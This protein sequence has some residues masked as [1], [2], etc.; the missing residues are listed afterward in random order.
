MVPDNMSFSSPLQCDEHHI[1]PPHMSTNK[2]VSTVN[3]PESRPSTCCCRDTYSALTTTSI[4]LP[5]VRTRECSQESSL[6]IVPDNMLL[7]RSY[8][9]PRERIVNDTLVQLNHFAVCVANEIRIASPI[10]I[11]RSIQRATRCFKAAWRANPPTNAT[12]QAQST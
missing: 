6:G 11:C 1:I 3:S 5:H 2:A 7:L 4:P 12:Y 10:R 9:W 8:Q